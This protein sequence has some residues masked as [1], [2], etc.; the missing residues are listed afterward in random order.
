ML[1]L[2]TDRM[3]DA[4]KSALRF[5]FLIFMTWN[6]TSCTK[7]IASGVNHGT[8]FVIGSGGGVSGQYEEYRVYDTGLVQ[9]FDFS[10]NKYVP[11]SYL[12]LKKLN[13]T[14]GQ[15]KELQIDKI[16]LDAP[17]NFT[18]YIEWFNDGVSYKVKWNDELMNRPK[19]LHEFF[20]E[21]EHHLKNLK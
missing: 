19:A 8:Y 12:N 18:Y 14:W 1:K 17:G 21:T 5:A 7:K 13:E 11:Y 16:K 20:V 9:W 10:A 4:T 15:L 2:T 3:G 6:M